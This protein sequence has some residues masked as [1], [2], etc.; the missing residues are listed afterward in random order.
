M[1]PQNNQYSAARS[2]IIFEGEEGLCWAV[3]KER[4]GAGIVELLADIL[5]LLVG[6]PHL[7]GVAAHRCFLRE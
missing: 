3:G 1:S 7:E 6:Q 2:A 4:E 5:Q